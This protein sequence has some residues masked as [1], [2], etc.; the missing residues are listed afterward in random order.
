MIYR[1]DDNNI[2]QSTI[3]LID[4]KC[5]ENYSRT[6]ERR[7]NSYMN[8][9]QAALE[10]ATGD[11]APWGR[12]KLI[13]VGQGRA[14][15]TS[16]IRRL[17]GQGF[18]A[19]EA[20]TLGVQ[21]EQEF[22]VDLSR[23]VNGFVEVDPKYDFVRKHHEK[24]ARLRYKNGGNVKDEGELAAT[25][26]QLPIFH[27]KIVEEESFGRSTPGSEQPGKTAQ[28]PQLDEEKQEECKE[29]TGGV[30]VDS[31]GEGEGEEEEELDVARR[32]NEGIYGT[33]MDGK[34]ETKVQ[35][36]IWDSRGQRVFYALH[37][38]FLTEY[39]IYAL[40]FD[41]RELLSKE[42][43]A[44]EYLQFWLKSIALHAPNAPIVLIGTH[45]DKV[46]DMMKWKHIDTVLRD[47]VNTITS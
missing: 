17:L 11:K 45:R 34:E 46:A 29:A 1:L 7:R 36:T 25:K 14:G 12:A 6:R 4:Q 16:T 27:E 39:G 22:S 21:T 5:R 19:N 10:Q 24:L 15:K 41:M 8:R 32:Y 38:L 18:N 40:V 9:A 3:A 30:Y 20:S 31:E 26:R 47:S 13:V 28:S 2:E 42:D 43:D 35:L 33:I 37:H 23:T 44:V